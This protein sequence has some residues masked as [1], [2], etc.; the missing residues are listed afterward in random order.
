MI[1][2]IWDLNKVLLNDI[3]LP[4]VLHAVEEFKFYKWVPLLACY[5]LK[6]KQD[7]VYKNISHI[8]NDCAVSAY[9]MPGAKKA[10]DMATSIPDV[11]NDVCSNIAVSGD[12]KDLEK[13]FRKK[14]NGMNKISEYHLLPPDASK[15]YIYK[16]AKKH[17][18]ITYV[19]DDKLKNI[20]AACNTGCLP[21]FISKSDKD[22]K[23][24]TER[25]GAIC[26]NTALEFV[27]SLVK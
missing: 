8:A 1:K 19:V 7:Y 9:F 15:E 16:N 3:K 2:I 10:I 27:Q 18:E 21:V 5:A 17:F 6:V 14:S 11:V 13:E 24:A 25:Y 20:I 12:L 4:I 26:F 23:I 22:I